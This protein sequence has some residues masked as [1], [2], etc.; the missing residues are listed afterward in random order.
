MEESLGQSAALGNFFEP[1]QS[2]THFG[3]VPVAATSSTHDA[4][5]LGAL[6]QE[7]SV[8]MHIVTNV[9]DLGVVQLVVVGEE[10]P[11][12]ERRE[13]LIFGGVCLPPAQ[14]DVAGSCGCRGLLWGT[15]AL[16]ELRGV[17]ASQVIIAGESLA[18]PALPGLAIVA[19]VQQAPRAGVRR[20][21]AHVHVPAAEGVSSSPRDESKLRW[22]HDVAGRVE[23]A[24]ACTSWQRRLVHRLTSR[25][26]TH[27]VVAF[28]FF[29]RYMLACVHVEIHLF[30]YKIKISL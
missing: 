3:N 8:A 28:I 14:R 24:S 30:V 17:H 10:G 23:V 4:H 9:A 5:V 16:S 19:P 6:D 22:G 26:V 12:Q 11:G 7:A 1:D 13:E 15:G 20:C 25:A 21:R 27:S 2:W 18:V 29:C